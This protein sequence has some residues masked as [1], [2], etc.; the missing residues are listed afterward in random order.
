MSHIATNQEVMR[1]LGLDSLLNLSSS[2]DIALR[3]STAPVVTA[4]LFVDSHKL[5]QCTKQFELHA[6]DSGRKPLQGIE[7]I[8][9]SRTIEIGL[10]PRAFNLEAACMNAMQYLDLSINF[11]LER[12]LRAMRR[13]SIAYAKK[14][15][16]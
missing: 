13:H 12:H 8:D 15:G 9:L 5:K 7:S 4:T 10:P 6:V 1:V 11:I 14:R 16:I 2:V 3:P